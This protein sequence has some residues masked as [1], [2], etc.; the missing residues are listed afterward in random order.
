MLER[1]RA[2]A[3]A[4]PLAPALIDGSSG[5]VTSREALAMRG[6]ELAAALRDAGLREGELVALQLPNS[7]DFVA[8]FLAALELRLV[9]VPIDRDAPETEVARILGHF[10]V[11]FAVRQRSCRCEIA[12]VS[13]TAAHSEGL[14]HDA[15]LV[16]L[17]SGSTGLP[18]GIVASEANLIADATNICATMDIRPEDLNLGAIPFSHSYGF[19][20]LVTPLLLHGTAVVFSNE[21]LPQSVLDLC[22][23][24]RCTVVPAIP[25]VFDHL[26][27]TAK[28][29]FETVR[30]FLSA[31]APLPA[32]TSRRFRERFGLPIHTFYGCSECGG[33]TYDRAGAAVERGTVGTA[34]ENVQL[35]LAAGRLTVRSDSVA[36]GYLHD[37]Q[38][39]VPF[40][41]GAFVTDDLIETSDDGEVVIIGRASD[42]INTAGKKVNPREVEQVIAQI[43]GVRQVKVYGEPAG[44]RGEVVAAAVVASADVTREAIRTYCAER[45]SSHKVPRIVKL[46][47]Q[48]PIDERGKVRRSLLASL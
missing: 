16:K 30:T 5:A 26:A 28:G 48:I 25:M 23:R 38:S 44:A 24:F 33:I 8:A 43:E 34:M 41:G 7:V 46:I 29:D 11:A 37:A 39:F 22:N 17:T 35:D 19:S 10:G 21:Y 42:L 12:K 2:L 4:A 45:L 47:E 27:T 15:R 20:N 13:T 31:G 3:E 32:A 18:K 9:V 1:F 14:P 36:L 40:D 6:S